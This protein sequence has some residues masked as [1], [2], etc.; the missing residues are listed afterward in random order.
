MP[1]C[2]EF[3]GLNALGTI[4]IASKHSVEETFYRTLDNVVFIGKN[5]PTIAVYITPIMRRLK[6]SSP[7]HHSVK[8]AADTAGCR[9][10]YL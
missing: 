7:H 1:S 4:I 10:L 2:E 9:T 8:T 6:P 3:N 5:T